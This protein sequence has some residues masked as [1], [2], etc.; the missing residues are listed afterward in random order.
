MHTLD[1]PP[2]K[3]RGQP[4]GP[5]NPKD[6]RPDTREQPAAAERTDTDLDSGSEKREAPDSD[7]ASRQPITNQDEQDRVTNASQ[8]R[9][10]PEK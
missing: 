8:D 3:K 1:K 7:T 6:I 5:A 4:E 10:V 2:R 9:P